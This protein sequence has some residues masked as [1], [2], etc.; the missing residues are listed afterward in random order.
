[1][2]IVLIGPPGSGKGTQSKRIAE[3]LHIQHISSGALFRIAVLAGSTLGK[4]AE[5]Y[6]K[7]GL[8]VP[9]ELATGI[10]AERI[11]QSICENG[12]VLD[13]FPRNLTQARALDS[14]LDRINKPIQQVFVIEVTDAE[15]IARITGRRMDPETGNIY[16]NKFEP[17]PDEIKSRLV[18]RADDTEET[19]KKRLA[20]YNK[21]TLPIIAFYAERGIVHKISGEGKP[22]VVENRLLEMLK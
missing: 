21:E 9:D 15:V 17:A 2:R 14:D 22:D 1:M 19:V 11:K 6:M 16:H 10:V 20:A 18:Q 8:L 3:R 5:S 4:A 12:F 13:G 7:N